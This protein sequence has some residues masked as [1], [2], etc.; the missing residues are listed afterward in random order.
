MTPTELDSQ[1]PVKV[2]RW[3]D[4]NSEESKTLDTARVVTKQAI[5]IGFSRGI[6]MFDTFGRVWGLNDEDKKF[7]PLHFKK[8]D[9]VI[10]YRMSERAAN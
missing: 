6:M 5:R 7:Y 10:G 9:Q 4:F 2:D 1:S 3:I 8:G